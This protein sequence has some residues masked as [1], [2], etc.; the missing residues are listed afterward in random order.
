MGAP[1]ARMDRAPDPY[2]FHV[3]R[4]AKVVLV[5]R[6]LAPASL[7][8]RFARSPAG[9]F[10]AV[11][12]PSAVARVGRENLPAAQALGF[13]L[14]GHGSPAGAACCQP[15]GHAH[16]HT[17]SPSPTEG[18][19]EENKTVEIRGP[20]KMDRRKTSI[21]R[22]TDLHGNQLAADNQAQMKGPQAVGVSP[23]APRDP[24]GIMLGWT[25]DPT[26][27]NF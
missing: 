22:L 16:Q 20:K 21:F 27:T 4:P 11:L 14:V 23:H 5:L 10:W 19:A 18:K 17:T 8:R 6:L 2:P 15:K 25:P 26:L 12:L 3:H 1:V 9:R 7:P 13:A 24:V